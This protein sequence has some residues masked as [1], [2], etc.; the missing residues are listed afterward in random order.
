M[1]PH[2]AKVVAVFCVAGVLAAA[3]TLLL[4]WWYVPLLFIADGLVLFASLALAF[5]LCRACGWVGGASRRRYWEAA[6]LIVVGYPAAEVCGTIAALICEGVLLLTP[7]AWHSAHE[8]LLWI[9]L[10]AFWGTVAAAFAVSTALM[11][12]NEAW[13]SRVLLLLILAGVA[14]TA[15][16]LAIYVP[17]YSATEGFAA[18]YREL[19]LFGVLLPLGNVLFSVL[20]GYGLMRRA[21][22][23]AAQSVHLHAAARR[24]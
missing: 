23:G 13:D 3:L 16:A 12:I 7:T 8:P 11:V 17:N 21:D 14:T 15:V 5:A 20:G 24:A 18:R 22:T 9:G 10:L 2:A 19:V 1:K 4:G 6:A